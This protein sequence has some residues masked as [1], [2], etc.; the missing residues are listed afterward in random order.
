MNDPA[1]A[2]PLAVLL[3]LTHRCPL[4]CAYCSNPLALTPG[5]S[6]LSTG[7]WCA[8][9]DQAA[10]LGVLQIHFSGGE[11]M[12]REDLPELVSHAS[13]VGLYSNLITSGVLLDDARLGALV[14]A[15]LSHIQLSFQGLEE[16]VAETLS[17]FRDGVARKR[18]ALARVQ[19][20]GLALTVNFVVTRQNVGQLDAIL[21]YADE[22]GIARVEVANTQY[23]GWALQ[24]RA[25]LMPTH[26]Q[27]HGM[28]LLVEEW[29][30]R[31]KGRMVID[32]VIPDY[33]G[34]RPKA[35][36]GGWARHFLN[37]MPD[38]TILPCHAAQTLKHLEY[39]R[40]PVSTLASAWFESSA[41][42]AYRGTGWMPQPCRSCDARER[43][44]GGCRCQALALTG[45]AGT[46]DPV[47]E[48]SPQHE[49]VVMLAHRE[50]HRDDVR[51]QLRRFSI[52]KADTHAD[53]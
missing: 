28:S 29:R 1:I 53:A 36:M 31:V 35:C 27:I 4:R 32:Y 15:G 40:F 44:W 2:P 41:F 19:A 52:Q 45:D 24:N 14:D 10:E 23:Y 30:E 47:C 13:K 48:Y 39:P 34:R 43:D 18:E 3:E 17:G 26:A 49:H 7:D 9:L 38:G 6:E 16:G 5:S 33:Y 12:A 37:V 11:P 51:L 25:A 20:S 42:A 21:R 8:V 46:L 22:R 50:S